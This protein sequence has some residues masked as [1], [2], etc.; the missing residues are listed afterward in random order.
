M[1]PSTYYLTWTFAATVSHTI[2]LIL[3]LDV[4]MA[5][6]WRAELA[7]ASFLLP[8]RVEL[9]RS[10]DGDQLPLVAER[11]G[12]HLVQTILVCRTDG[13]DDGDAL[14][15]HANWYN[16]TKK[17][18]AVKILAHSADGVTFLDISIQCLFY[19]S[20][21]MISM[22]RDS[23]RNRGFDMLS[24]FRKISIFF[25]TRKVAQTE[26][27]D[28]LQKFGRPFFSW[29]TSL[30]SSRQPKC[31]L[32]RN[33]RS[34]MNPVRGVAQPSAS[35]WTHWRSSCKWTISSDEKCN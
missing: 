13:Q 8:V 31:W 28:P 24:Q 14:V 7:T 11:N 6:M 5:R 17:W 15:G 12:C 27:T 20:I 19:I 32:W 33:S 16:G 4:W 10:Q 3:Y 2:H 30:P 23:R 9:G 35:T 25:I 22:I 21:M 1:F 18:N 26:Y 29:A 34:F